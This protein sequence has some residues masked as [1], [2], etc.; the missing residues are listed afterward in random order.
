[1]KDFLFGAICRTIPQVMSASSGANKYY[2]AT[3]DINDYFFKKYIPQAE[4]YPFAVTEFT[5]DNTGRIFAQSGVGKDFQ[6][7]SNH[8]TKYYYSKPTQEE[9]DRLFGSEAGNASHYLKNMVVD[10]NG[11]ISVSYVN[12]SGKTIATALAGLTPNN[13][14]ALNSNN[15]VGTDVIKTLLMPQDFE[16]DYSAGMLLGNTSFL[17]AVSGNYK[18]NYSIT[19]LRLDILHGA[20]NQLKICNTCYY[21]LTI[22]VKDNCNQVLKAVTIPVDPNTIFQTNCTVTPSPIADNFTLAISNIG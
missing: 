21:D 12:A 11:Q 2:S 13:V 4:G 22:T 6:P 7:G 14:E 19:P 18:F 1:Y 15:G 5:P 17:A 20:S 3:N 10:P 9:L 8:E 16:K